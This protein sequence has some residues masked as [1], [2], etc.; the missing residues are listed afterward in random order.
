LGIVYDFHYEELVKEFG[1]KFVMQFAR[2]HTGSSTLFIENIEQFQDI[3]SQFGQRMVKVSE[4]IG[5]NAYTINCCNTKYGVLFGGL[6][7]QITGN[8]KLTPLAGG[9]IGND[10]ADHRDWKNGIEKLSNEI[11]IIGEQMIKNGYFGLFGLDMIVKENGE[12]VIIEINARQPASIPMYTKM[13]IRTGEIP[14]ALLHLAEF[15]NIE[16]S[17]NVDEYNKK[18]C[19]TYKNSQIFI[20]AFQDIKISSRFQSGIYR[21]Q[22]DNA[23]YDPVKEE[24]INNAIF[25]DEQKDKSLL[26]QKDAY[27]IDQ[28]EGNEGILVLT[29]SEGR[30]IKINDEFARIQLN[31]N[32]IIAN[33]NLKPWIIEVLQ[34]I[35][36]YQK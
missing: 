11:K 24:R 36:N 13:Q 4:Y 12:H 2:G 3:Q 15:L 9:T 20:R 23:G 31:Q 25:L 30:T 34:A 19:Q 14:L 18:A 32:A 33:N 26:K 5:G 1:N 10:W 6:S 35:Y 21:L 29:Q 8:E 17:I 7:K 16:Y 27:C 22:G 28:L